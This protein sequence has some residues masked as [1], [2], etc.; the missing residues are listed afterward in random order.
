MSADRRRSVMT[1]GR[2]ANRRFRRQAALG[3]AAAFWAV[4]MT[5][6]ALAAPLGPGDIAL[7]GW[8]D[9]LSTDQFAFVNLVPLDAGQEIYF[10]DNGW[11]GT[12]FRGASA[13]DGD[14][15]ETLIKFTA[16]SAI[17]AGSIISNV[18]AGAFTWTTSGS[19]P[20]T[21]SGAF[22]H[23]A[24][25]TSGDQIYAFT[26][27]TNNPLFNPTAHLFVLDDTGAFED[28]ISASSGSVPPGL[29]AGVNALTFNQAGSGQNFMAFNTAALSSGTKLE[30]LAAIANP[31]NWILGASG[32]LPSGSISVN[33]GG[34]RTLTWNGT[35]TG[36]WN[37]ADQ[38][39]DG[40]AGATWNSSNP[41]S[42]VFT[43]N[44]L[45]QIS[46]SA[47]VVAGNLT[48]NAPVPG[49]TTEIFG[50]AGTTLTLTAPGGLG[51]TASSNAVFN[52][53]VVL[54]ATQTW[55]IA[56]NYS[57]TMGA[58][59]QGSGTGLIKAGEGLL[60]LNV[61]STYGGPT[62]LQAGEL[63][64]NAAL[65]SPSVLTVAGNA[66]LSGTGTV[67]SPTAVQ[68]GGR[69]APGPGTGILTFSGG[70]DLSAGGIFE[71][72]LANTSMTPGVGFDQLRILSGPLTLGNLSTLNLKFGPGMAPNRNAEYWQTPQSWKIVESDGAA[73]FGT[74]T[75][76]LN[77][78]WIAGRFEI[79]TGT[80]ADLHDLFLNFIPNTGTPRDLVWNGANGQ[81][82]GT[83]NWLN[84]AVPA[85]WDSLNPDN[86]Q[87]TGRGSSMI[88]LGGTVTAGQLWF[89]FN[90]GPYQIS[91][92]TLR[93]AGKDW[94]SIYAYSPVTINAPVQLLSATNWIVAY[95]ST[96]TV[97]GPISGTEFLSTSG[98]RLVLSQGNTF[99]G[100]FY[101]YWSRVSFAHDGANG[102]AET[103]L[104]A[105]TYVY[106]DNTIY[107]F[108][109]TS[110][111][112]S[113][114]TR[115]FDIG[116]SGVTFH[117]QNTSANGWTI[118]G[119][120]TGSSTL[121]KSGP[122]T[123]RLGA[124][125]A[126]QGSANLFTGQVDIQEGTLTFISSDAS[127]SRT[128]LRGAAVNVGLQGT[129]FSAQELRI[130]ELSGNGTVLARDT[131]STLQPG[132]DIVIHA[133]ADAEFGGV[134]TNT[135]AGGSSTRGG[136]IVRGIGTQTLAGFTEIDGQVSV[137][138]SATLV[139]GGFTALTG[140][141]YNVNL[142]GGTFVLDNSIT[143]STDRL[144]DTN[145][146]VNINGG[147]RFKYISN[148]AGSTETLGPIVMNS[149]QATIEI[150][151]AD[152][153]AATTL[154]LLGLRRAGSQAA[155]H[156]QAAG[157]V[158]LGHPN[159]RIFLPALPY[160]LSGE[161]LYVKDGVLASQGSD[162][163]FPPSVGFATV[164]RAYFAAN[165]PMGVAGI[166]AAVSSPLPLTPGGDATHNGNVNG[167]QTIDASTQDFM[168]NTLRLEPLTAGQ[169]LTVDGPYNL[170]VGAIL[171]AGSTD[172]AIEAVNGARYGSR[173]T[174]YIHV[175]EPQ[176]TLTLHAD[177]GVSYTYAT[178]VQVTPI[179]KSGEGTLSLTAESTF[180]T[181][182]VN[183]GSPATNINILG[184][185]LRATADSLPNTNT[186]LRFRGGVFELSG[187]GT[188]NRTL[189]N[190]SVATGAVNWTQG[191]S[192]SDLGSGGFSAIN[193]DAVVD[194]NTPG[195]RDN[196][197][198]EDVNFV[199]AGN[200]LI[201]G[202]M[203]ADS[204]IEWYDNLSL[205]NTAG[206]LAYNMREIRVGHNPSL[207][208]VQ[209]RARISGAISSNRF[210]DL[211]KTGGGALEIAG[212]N[213]WV[214]GGLNGGV[215]VA[216]GSLLLS[217]SQALGNAAY[218]QLGTRNSAASAGIYTFGP[219]WIGNSIT[220]VAGQGSERWLG[221]L[222]ADESAFYGNITLEQDVNLAAQEG[223][224]NFHAYMTG[225]G[226][227]KVFGP[228][229]ISLTSYNWYQGETTLYG[230][231][232]VVQTDQ[233]MGSYHVPLR[234][235][236]GTLA[237]EQDLSI[238][239]PIIVDW[240]GG[241]IA[242][243]GGF[244]TLSAGANFI[245]GGINV[246]LT[247]W[248]DTQ[249][250]G[251]LTVTGS[252]SLTLDRNQSYVEVSP[253]AALSM[254][255]LTSL[256][257]QGDNS[258]LGSNGNA[259][260]ISTA[261]FA[262]FTVVSGDH[263]V[264]NIDGEGATLIEAGASLTASRVRQ[265]LLLI[266][267][268]STLRIAPG[269]SNETASVLGQLHIES[270][271]DWEGTLDLANNDLVILSDEWNADL[272][273]AEIRDMVRSGRN[274]NRGALWTGMGITSSQ[275]A[276]EPLMTLAVRRN[277]NSDGT[278]L[279]DFFSGIAVDEN[280]I[281]I[282]Y[283]YN[284]DADLDGDV[285]GADY[286]LAD[287]GFL[288]YRGGLLTAPGFDQ[289]DFDYNGRIDADDFFLIDRA[290]ALQSAPINPPGGPG[291]LASVPEPATIGLLAVAAGMLLGRRRRNGP[292]M[293]G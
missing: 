33:T 76:L 219:V 211:L 44:G 228:G 9:N 191:T 57:V 286:A 120:I 245:F 162:A 140:S 214:N 268:G 290:F 124:P 20:G 256:R 164:D 80:G 144:A 267:S 155:I 130:G 176:A 194:L 4:G 81:W 104:G 47:S 226:G 260:N 152:E 46:L 261:Q 149:G 210:N 287:A 125:T 148:A 22:A 277:R 141:N 13:S 223:R 122:G 230:G 41:D 199:A 128:A 274:S 107:E 189:G 215:I 32:T 127:V 259:L 100:P 218:V 240:A 83:G 37:G 216:E 103:A 139:F 289:G 27:P 1:L 221:G 138:G 126:G 2:I 39:L 169:V 177:L 198:W 53:P 185:V 178:G 112:V 79:A 284:G 161:T 129:L 232:L 74:F 69:V 150:A 131:T 142:R 184:G 51:I 190:T 263:T 225:P 6:S 229:T 10:T 202:S 7:I 158:P 266:D 244:P 253:G 97:T 135:P 249:W 281:L 40:G 212:D 67:S 179:T 86:A 101:S 119:S 108:S 21:T 78:D 85:T 193:G 96:L 64:V 204:V 224:T 11:T 292:T 93:L 94:V 87:F 273:L 235:S 172:F 118:N 247:E 280:S 166:V 28:A 60:V 173:Q 92:G 36:N 98:G 248:G 270:G 137:A 269:G 62:V 264:G 45:S 195:Q 156:F 238:A 250:H 17:P 23:L 24:L 123:L 196:L 134:I 282:K 3:A 146:F 200:A 278:A 90:T 285:D 77:N 89:D 159:A 208:T 147:G 132:R 34:P 113:P 271:T 241:T 95:N 151:Y 82:N 165:D 182:T 201:F 206:N 70:L 38:W 14:G 243:G 91:G 111:V 18:S 35:V 68:T 43:G 115:T 242:T 157:Q 171:L 246:H 217:D 174:R 31:A 154:T 163:T 8:I 207:P 88:N 252:G 133:L 293:E 71:W 106:G 12:Q 180:P 186:V 65:G 175:M 48:F 116:P 257:L 222:G 114:G 231:K 153:P 73:T 183:A 5:G 265:S 102:A 110:S 121:K 188:I 56:A 283:T 75:N 29:T 220:V 109:G 192:T 63:R 72:D 167:S 49:H 61:S 15:S 170:D 227:V 58:A 288:A 236:G 276:A 136:L 237:P 105:G 84:G 42:A 197:A 275:A 187:G 279:Y 160:T 26:G 54:G 25:A 291:V 213:S 30:W 181:N 234:F 66:L 239:R 99:T 19:V 254:Q 262:T 55:D 203:H 251:Q 59:I 272:L 233:N 145:R 52:R 258:T 50:S 209:G 205:T 255:D 143:N 168:L 16:N 117:I